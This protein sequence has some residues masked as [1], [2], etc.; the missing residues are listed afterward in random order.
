MTELLGSTPSQTVGPYLHMGLPWQDG[1]YVVAEGT[2]GAVWIRG[3]VC[4]GAGEPIPD[5]LVETWQAN[6][7]GRFDHPDDPR[8]AVAGWRGFGRSD[9]LDGG[10]FAIHTVVPGALPGPHGTIQ[11]PHIDVSVFARGMLNRVVTRI[12]FPEFT[13][14][15]AVDPVLSQVQQDR[16]GTLI[17][18]RTQHGYRFDV[19]IQGE[20]ETVFF[21][22]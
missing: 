20:G 16:R 17:A 11:A 18:Q 10:V 19:R 12:Y 5:A 4:D 14:A 9:T 6:R 8:G 7:D 2:P 13:D 21:D 3:A 22:V 15:N 1:P